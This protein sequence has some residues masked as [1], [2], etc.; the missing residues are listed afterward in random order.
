MA[1]PPHTAFRT[2]LRTALVA[3][4]VL[5]AVWAWF[6]WATGGVDLRPSGIPFRS[7]GAARVVYTTLALLTLYLSLFATYARHDVRRLLAWVPAPDAIRRFSPPLVAALSVAITVLGVSHGV[8]T[9]R[10][11]DEYGYVSQADLWLAGN[12][13][14]DQPIARQVPW[15]DADWTFSPMGYRPLQRRGSSGPLYP[16]GLPVLMAAAAAVAGECGK[17]LITPFL[18]G[19]TIWLTYMLGT[20]LWSPMVGV[21]AAILMSTSPAFL[22]MLMLPM[23]DVPAAA[24]FALGLVLALSPG[25]RRELWAGAAVS[26][27]IFVRPNLVPLGLI[28][29]AFLVMRARAEG[30]GSRAAMR[31]AVW[32][33]L[34]AGPLVLAVAILNTVLYG[35]PWAASYG[36]LDVLFSWTYPV[37]NVV[38]YSR[39]IWR[40]E[41]P[42]VL[43]ALMPM[44]MLRRMP[45]ERRRST[46]L[47]GVFALGVFACY[48]FYA[49]FGAW[50]FLRFLLPA[51]PVMLALAAIGVFI[52]TERMGVRA[53]IAIL[54]LTV[55]IAVNLRLSVIRSEPILTLWQGGISYVSAAEYVRNELPENAVVVALHHAGSVRYYARRLTMRWDM[56]PADWWPRAVDVL[57]ANGYRPYVL[58]ADFEEQ[59]FRERL[60]LSEATDAPGVVV[61]T[62]SMPERLRLY[63][64]LRLTRQAEPVEIP[65]IV[66]QPCACLWPIERQPGVR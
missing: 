39:Y 25:K 1:D 13:V 19:L 17:F 60:G 24:F 34:G 26:M 64:P 41:T 42:V 28:V 29:L 62:L 15:P 6:V 8:F 40:T 36:N 7:T 47:V 59:P 49:P 35:A 2:F 51:F 55:A 57:V 27:G 18:G 48:L 65:Q 63:D 30:G 20:R 12:L 61:A 23:S 50:W 21:A 37:Q 44:L 3:S 46:A 58:L 33:G 56:L 5:S 14:I 10:A 31:A 11:A 4:I 43:L 54:F 53:G 45:P 9:A 16:P 38:N 66:A 52:A 22:Y 32:Y